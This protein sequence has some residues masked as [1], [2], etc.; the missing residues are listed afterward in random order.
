MPE[1][2]IC[3]VNLKMDPGELGGMSGFLE[4]KTKGHF[5]V[6]MRVKH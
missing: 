1:N 3:R 5:G 4:G 6:L 2:M